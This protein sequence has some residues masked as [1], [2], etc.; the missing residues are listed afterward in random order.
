MS[1]PKYKELENL[2][3][4]EE[5]DQEIFILQKNLFDLRIKKS[6]SQTVKPHLFVHAKRRIAQLKSKKALLL[7]SSN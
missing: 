6:T 5:I 2:K 7:K 4:S 3:T 1:L